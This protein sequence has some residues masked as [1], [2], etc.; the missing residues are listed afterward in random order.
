MEKNLFDYTKPLVL[1]TNLVDRE[2]SLHK[3]LSINVE[4][5]D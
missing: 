4:L 2:G 5:K 3:V 1:H